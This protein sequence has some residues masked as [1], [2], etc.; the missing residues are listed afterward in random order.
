MFC[1]KCIGKSITMLKTI[2]NALFILMILISLS[3]KSTLAE[4]PEE[5][6]IQF[7]LVNDGPYIFYDDDKL[8]IKWVKNDLVRRRKITYDNTDFIKRKF[9]IDFYTDNTSKT[10]NFEQTF[11]NADTIIAI[12][13][14]HGQYDIAIELLRMH[15]VIDRNNN[16]I[17]RNNHLVILGDIF[18]R[19]NKVTELLWLFYNLENQA[20]KAGGKV[21][22]LLGNHEL[23]IMHNDLRYI[24]PKYHKVAS[25][26]G[27]SYT[28]LFLENSVLGKWIR[29]KPVL[30]TI[31]DILFTHA[32]ISPKVIESG[33][34]KKQINQLYIENIYGNDLM[35]IFKDSTLKLLIG[36]Y[37]PLWYRGYYNVNFT[38][39]KL[40]SVLNYFNVNHLAIGHTS[41]PSV[42]PIYNNKLLNIDS[43]IKEGNYGE[44]LIIE[45]KNFYRGTLHGGKIKL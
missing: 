34:N 4:N 24:H 22:V 26:M 30:I 25:L 9:N 18:D 27:T 23:M 13:D 2:L 32:G 45:N 5:Q 28:N 1:Y 7:V 19:G 41:L 39:E 20:E 12:S 43:N 42:T 10:K 31:N 6:D 15:K 11:T 44:V 17:M 3:L 36:K 40:D 35:S 21:H 37:G 8:L 14:I 33:L 16:W 29:S 38:E